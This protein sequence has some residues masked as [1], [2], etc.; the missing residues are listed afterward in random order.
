MTISKEYSIE[1]SDSMSINLSA[2]ISSEHISA[3]ACSAFCYDVPK[4]VRV[5]AVIVAIGELSQVQRQVVLTD[6]VIGADHATLEQ[7]PEAI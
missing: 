1:L 5:L 2:D 4:D 7:A 6:L 3:V